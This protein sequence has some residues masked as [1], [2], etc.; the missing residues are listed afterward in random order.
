MKANQNVVLVSQ[1]LALV[2]YARDHVPTYHNWMLDEE[3]RALT[4][5]EPLTLEE[6]Y[7]MQLERGRG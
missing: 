6:E 7:E 1:R 3:L 5:S 4:A 2:P